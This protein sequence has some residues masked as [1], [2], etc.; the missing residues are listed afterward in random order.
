MR[1]HQL[2]QGKKWISKLS[3]SVAMC[4][5]G[6]NWEMIAW[7]PM[8]IWPNKQTSFEDG[9]RPG[10]PVSVRNEY[11]VL[12]WRNVLKKIHIYLFM[13]YVKDVTFQ[14]AQL[15][16][17]CAMILTWKNRGKMDTPSP[18]RPTSKRNRE[19][20]VERTCS[21]CLN[22]MDPNAFAASSQVMKPGCTFMA[23]LT[24]GPVRCG[25]LLTRRDQLCF[26]QISR[27]RSDSFKFF[28][29]CGGQSW[30]TFYHRIQHS[31]QNTL[32]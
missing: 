28:P 12:L 8:L 16:G 9:H 4:W 27:V 10:R 30:L 7:K 13:K 24:N 32:P 25:W 17:L 19:L 23:S 14:L 26:D 20:N 5:H 31:L 6:W 15:K 18:N 3:N 22:Q 11:T 2:C 1:C 21:K 29:I